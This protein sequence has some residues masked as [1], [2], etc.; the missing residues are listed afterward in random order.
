MCFWCSFQF[1]PTS[2]EAF[3]ALVSLSHLILLTY[4][5]KMVFVSHSGRTLSLHTK[6][7]Q[8]TNFKEMSW[9]VTHSIVLT[10]FGQISTAANLYWVC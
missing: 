6:E 10:C 7:K 9:N 1:S 3:T 4:T 2:L 8:M 5:E